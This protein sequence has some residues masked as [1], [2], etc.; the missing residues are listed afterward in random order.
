MRFVYTIIPLNYEVTIL[1]LYFNYAGGKLKIEIK[2]VVISI[3]TFIILYPVLSLH[4]SLSRLCLVPSFPRQIT[5]YIVKPSPILN[6][7]TY[8]GHRREQR[9]ST[10]GP[11]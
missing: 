6:K 5:S 3:S 4:L 7:S 11:R 8:H 1:V 10:S 2:R 9:F